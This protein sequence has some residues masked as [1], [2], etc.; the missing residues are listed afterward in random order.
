[1]SEAISMTNLPTPPNMDEVL[2]MLPDDFMADHP[3]TDRLAHAISAWQLSK[4]LALQS[5]EFLGIAVSNHNVTLN[6]LVAAQKSMTDAQLSETIDTW[7]SQF[8]A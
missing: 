7:I 2:A 3:P 5:Q 8:K 1:M 6:L 4:S